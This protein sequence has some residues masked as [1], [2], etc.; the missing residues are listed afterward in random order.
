MNRGHF[1]VSVSACRK[2][3]FVV[4]IGTDQAIN[5]I[6]K[7]K[8]KKGILI[9][10]LLD[11][12]SYILHLTVMSCLEPNCVCNFTVQ[13]LNFAVAGRLVNRVSNESNLCVTCNHLN[14]LHK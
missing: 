3:C 8:K 7:F 12:I 4:A 13:D 2:I 14:G 10:V 6:S 11:I 1:C 5:S 9:F